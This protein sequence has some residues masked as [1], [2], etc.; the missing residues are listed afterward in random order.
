[1]QIPSPRLSPCCSGIYNS[2]LSIPAEGEE[3]EGAE[4]GSP[5]VWA[6]AG[7]AGRAGIALLLPVCGSP[8]PAGSVNAGQGT[9]GLASPGGTGMDVTADRHS[10]IPSPGLHQ[11]A[12]RVPAELSLAARRNADF[13]G[14]VKHSELPKIK[15]RK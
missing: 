12:L 8:A 9:A 2:T 15:A 3:E 13:W 5:G 10:D 1:M 14:E 11:A 4:P 7:A 6:A